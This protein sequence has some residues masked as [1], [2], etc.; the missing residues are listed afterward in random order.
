MAAPVREGGEVVQLSSYLRRN[1]LTDIMSAVLEQ[2]PSLEIE[3]CATDDG[4]PYL[5]VQLDGWANI[6]VTPEPRHP[7][8]FGVVISDSDGHYIK[9]AKG[10]SAARAM[11]KVIHY[12]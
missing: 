8:K 4:T 3:L 11:F 1:A 9:I 10:V 12:S 2:K 6:M 5:S 7:G